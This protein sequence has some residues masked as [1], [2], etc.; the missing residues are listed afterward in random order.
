VRGGC[1][2]AS[3]R[4]GSPE[5][6]EPLVTAIKA[7]AI[8]PLRLWFRW[9]F[10]GIETI[11]RTG[12][13]L[14]ACN[15]VS[16]LD[17]VINAYG[18]VKAG[19]TPRFL[20]KHEL[21]GVP[22]LG[23]VLRATRQIPVRRGTRDRAPLES[24]ERALAA[25]EVVVVYP[26]GTVTDRPDHLPMRGKTGVV[27]LALASGLPVIPMA[28]WGSHPVWQRSGPGSLRPGRPLWVKVGEPIDV[29][30]VGPEPGGDELRA[31]TDE[32]MA[33]LTAVVV[34]LRARYPRAWS[35]DR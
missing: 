27:R 25:G 19:R 33:A 6:A 1:C 21:F 11:P 30:V 20:A 3:A 7:L 9:R 8:P 28:S 23:R 18:V 15:H 29:R 12:P 31:A 26:E 22:I 16:Y 35:D 4:P 5:L 17:P 32:V 13:V 14:I 10:E 24:A 2:D 34:D